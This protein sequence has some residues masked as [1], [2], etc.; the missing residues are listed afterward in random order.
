MGMLG[1]KRIM[2]KHI[3]LVRHGETEWN[4]ESR[5]QGHSDIPLN[6]TGIEQ[7]QQLAQRLKEW[8]IQYIC[9]SDLQRAY[10]TAEWIAEHKGLPVNIEPRLRER[11]F[12]QLEGQQFKMIQSKL[13]EGHRFG[14]ETFESL[15]ERGMSCI[16]S[17]LEGTESEHIL[18][19]SHGGFINSILHEISEGQVGTG[20]TRL[21]NTSLSHIE[22]NQGNWQLNRIN[23]DEHLKEK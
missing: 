13:K 14:V 5:I 9:S 10:H 11:H 7:A 16:R 20:V 17:I 18:I 22:Y 21:S 19:V 12:G 4:R 1:E 8:P 3:Y 6:S 15:K 23:D 2:I